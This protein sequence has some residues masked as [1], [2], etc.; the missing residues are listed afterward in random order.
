[1][2]G[3]R[4]GFSGTHGRETYDRS[5]EIVNRARVEDVVEVLRR[6]AALRWPI[7]LADEPAVVEQL[8]WTVVPGT[9]GP[10][11]E[12]DTRWPVNRSTAEFL[13]DRSEELTSI[14]FCV[15]DVVDDP[16]A[17]QRDALD[18]AFAELVTA[19]TSALGEPAQR[20][21]APAKVTWLTPTGGS[22]SVTHHGVAVQVDVNSAKL[23]E[24]KRILAR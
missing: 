11:L 16:A 18:D 21:R 23:T 10:Y 20:S 2:R 15:T 6:V 1:M 9:E 8:G 4:S 5:V 22:L 24:A 3:T 13:C 7:A 19:A 17:D 12:A 14:D